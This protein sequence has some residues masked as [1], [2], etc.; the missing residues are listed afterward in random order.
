[1]QLTDKVLGSRGLSVRRSFFERPLIC[2]A[3]QSDSSYADF[4]SVVQ[5]AHIALQGML[6]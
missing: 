6:A 5:R 2:L 4:V 3:R 1:M